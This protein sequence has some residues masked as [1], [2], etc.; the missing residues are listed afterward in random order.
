MA[1]RPTQSTYDCLDGNVLN[2]VCDTAQDVSNM[3]NDLLVQDRGLSRTS[4]GVRLH[5]AETTWPKTQEL[6]LK[7]PSPM[8]LRREKSTLSAN[9]LAALVSTRNN[10]PLV[11]RRHRLVSPPVRI[12][13]SNDKSF[14]LGAQCLALFGRQDPANLY[15]AELVERVWLPCATSTLATSGLLAASTFPAHLQIYFP[16]RL[17]ARFISPLRRRYVHVGLQASSA[18]RRVP[19]FLLALRTSRSTTVS[20]KTTLFLRLL[21]LNAGEARLSASMAAQR[22]ASWIQSIVD[23]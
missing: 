13:F 2:A 10:S 9:L 17:P 4:F 21:D 15:I 11:P 7:S 20:L 19:L 16:T 3:P 18:S 5:A 6:R 23:A 8:S 1:P 14:K 22:A 12:L